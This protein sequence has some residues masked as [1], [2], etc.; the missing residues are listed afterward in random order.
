[1]ILDSTLSIKTLQE[2]KLKSQCV[3]G[4]S[5]KTNL[6]GIY[7]KGSEESLKGCKHRETTAR[8]FVKGD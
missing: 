1:M 2:T 4:H 5:R 6:L 7:T 8:V 3:E